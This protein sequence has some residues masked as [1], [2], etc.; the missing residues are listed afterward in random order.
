MEADGRSITFRVD[1]V[2]E[3]E[4]CMDVQWM[5]RRK[6]W[7]VSFSLYLSSVIL[8]QCKTKTEG[9]TETEGLKQSECSFPLGTMQQHANN[10]FDQQ[11]WFHFRAVVLTYTKKQ[12]PPSSV[13]PSASASVASMAFRGLI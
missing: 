5:W 11:I 10:N 7:K 13:V 2:T 4:T 3:M 9:D 1:Q 12:C 8:S 6:E